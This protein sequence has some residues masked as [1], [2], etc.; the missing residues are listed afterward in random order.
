MY[1]IKATKQFM[2]TL[3]HLTKKLFKGNHETPQR[4]FK[5]R[6]E[7]MHARTHRETKG[8]EID[9]RPSIFCFLMVTKIFLEKPARLRGV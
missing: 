4:H 7:N 1:K 5:K 2:I 6:K 8:K 9:K 3:K